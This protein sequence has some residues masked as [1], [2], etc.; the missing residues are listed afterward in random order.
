MLVA[1]LSSIAS[2]N[3]NCKSNLATQPSSFP[4]TT[5][6]LSRRSLT[7][8]RCKKNPSLYV[9]H[10]ITIVCISLRGLIF[11]LALIFRK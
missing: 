10:Y 6:S 11:L 2:E 4:A 9:I 5:V 8:I 1:V 3:A 7:V